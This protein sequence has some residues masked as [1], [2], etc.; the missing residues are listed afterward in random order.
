VAPETKRD[1]ALRAIDE[2]PERVLTQRLATLNS[3][4][5]RQELAKLPKEQ[6]A[7]VKE[8]L[9][10]NREWKQESAL[11]REFDA[12]RTARLIERLFEVGESR[13][14][15]ALIEGLVTLLNEVIGRQSHAAKR[16]RPRGGEPNNLKVEEAIACLALE[17]D[18]IGDAIPARDLWSEFYNRL[19]LLGL[20]PQD[21]NDHYLYDG[22]K[23]ISFKTF[24]A[25]LSRHRRLGK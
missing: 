6:R 22:R 1:A 23:K 24:E 21:R 19:E 13:H 20:H 12:K 10:A 4:Q 16:P 9:R 11:L 7:R 17:V 18:A 3:E 5:R 15:C 2:N 14:A 25:R 8:Q